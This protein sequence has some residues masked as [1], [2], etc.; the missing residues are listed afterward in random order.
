MRKNGTIRPGPVILIRA[1]RASIIAL[2]AG[3]QDADDVVGD[4]QQGGGWRRGKHGGDLT[5]ELIL[6]GAQLA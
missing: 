5:G 6:S 3:L 1:M 4:L 2:A